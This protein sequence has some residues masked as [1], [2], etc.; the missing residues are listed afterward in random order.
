MEP[1]YNAVFFDIFSKSQKHYGKY[2]EPIC[3]AWELTRS[4][5][6][7]LL[8]LYNNPLFDR[9][10]DIVRCRGI[11]K[12][13]VSLSV[14]DLE[15]RGLLLRSFEPADRRTAHL[16]LTEQGRAI[17]AEGAAAQQRFFSALY[18]GITQAE[19]DRW[20]GIVQKVHENLEN[21]E[22]DE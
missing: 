7:V 19:I 16:K 8:F 10:A 11:A 3:K 14:K 21:M 6:D 17:A 9:A 20:K 1:T 12:S 15:S 18:T 5:M 4:E 22:I 2:L 13:H